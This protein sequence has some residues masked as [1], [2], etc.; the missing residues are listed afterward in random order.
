MV[1][2]GEE[3]VRHLVHLMKALLRSGEEPSAKHLRRLH[4]PRRSPE[5]IEEAVEAVFRGK[6]RRRR[7]PMLLCAE[8]LYS[9]MTVREI[10]G[11]YGRGSSAVSMAMK[12]IKR[13]S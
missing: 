8:R 6:R 4:E 13:G 12:A 5:E 3:F 7:A 11:R 10:A 9:W 2:G 1:L